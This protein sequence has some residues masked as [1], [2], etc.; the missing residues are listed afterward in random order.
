MTAPMTFAAHLRAILTLGL[1]LIGGHLAQF[2][3]GLT[4][5]VMLGWYGITDLADVTLAHGYFFAFFMFG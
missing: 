3:I 2:A 5:T 4:D 1:P